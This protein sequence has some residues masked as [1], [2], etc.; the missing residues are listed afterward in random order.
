MAATYELLMKSVEASRLVRWVSPTADHTEKLLSR[1]AVRT[2]VILVTF[3][4]YAG[5]TEHRS[6]AI[7]EVA[8]A[9][10]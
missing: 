1:E 5:S 8:S 9:I 4:E 2:H 10:V 6:R 3:R 7:E